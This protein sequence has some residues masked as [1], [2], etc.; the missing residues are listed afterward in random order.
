MLILGAFA[1]RKAAPALQQLLRQQ[2]RL[3]AGVYFQ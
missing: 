3:P 1:I 2:D